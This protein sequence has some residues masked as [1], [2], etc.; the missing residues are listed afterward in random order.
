VRYYLLTMKTDGA[1]YHYSGKVVTRSVKGEG[2]ERVSR[3]SAVA[4]AAYQSGERL[5]LTMERNP[6]GQDMQEK[7]AGLVIVHDY[8]PRAGDVAF[9]EICAPEG[10]PAWVFDRQDLWNRVEA[11][12]KRVDAQVCRQLDIALPR[13]LTH[14]QRI[15]LVREFVGEQF[16]SAG[17]VADVAFHYDADNHNPHCH[18]LLTTRKLEGDGFA[19]AKCKEWQPNFA[20]AGGAILADGDKMKEER[21]EWTRFCNKALSDAGSGLV[22]DHRTLKEQGIERAPTFHIGKDAWHQE[23]RTGLTTS[24]GERFKQLVNHNQAMQRLKEWTAQLKQRNPQ[25]SINQQLQRAKEAIQQ[26]ELFPAALSPA[27]ATTQ[28]RGGLYPTREMQVPP[29]SHDIINTREELE[30]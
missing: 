26:W 24:I 20:K 1:I 28:E 8:S 4:A 19:A 7:M 16:T 12:E 5:V 15:A 14:D 13:S 27:L 11:A 6:F 9:K 29:R 18:I 21:K 22:V 30:R 3:K 23:K 10:A 17:M 2:G 25:Y